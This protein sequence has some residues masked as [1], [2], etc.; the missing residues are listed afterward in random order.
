M[1]ENSPSYL[2]A[3]P[4]DNHTFSARLHELAM[5]ALCDY[6][7]Y[8]SVAK[9]ASNVPQI[10][11]MARARSMVGGALYDILASE[12]NVENDNV[13]LEVGMHL[14]R[15]GRCIVDQYDTGGVPSTL[16]KEAVRE[17]EEHTEVNDPKRVP[18]PAADH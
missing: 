15:W 14:L 18:A 13:L 8:L 12:A 16:G 1:N 11:D 2:P 9:D 3:K 5:G 17:G 7:V 10:R 6:D 4:A